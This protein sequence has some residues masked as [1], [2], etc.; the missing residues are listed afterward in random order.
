MHWLKPF[1]L[2]A[3]LF[4][5][6]GQVVWSA[7]EDMTACLAKG[8]E[9]FSKKQYEQA[10]KEFSRCVKKDRTNVDAHLSLAGVLLTLEDLQ[11]AEKSFH[12]ALKNM[13]RTSPYFS[14]TYSILGDIALKKQENEKAL[15]FY[16]RSL[17]FNAANVNSLVGKGVIIEYQGD[18]QG[19]S[20]YYR[21]ALAV[22]PLNLIARKRLI[23]LEPDYMTDAEILLSLK[24]RYAIAPETKELT[25]ED[26]NLF[27][28]IHRAEQRRGVDYLKNKKP[29]NL[30]SYYVTINKDSEFEREMLTL[31]G[32]KKLSKD[33]GQDAVAVFQRV[34]VPIQSI[35]D[36]RSLRGEK[37]F[38][39]ESTL[40][41]RGFFVYM[42]ALAGRK[43]FLL[44]NEAPPPTHAALEKIKKRV[45]ELKEAGYIEITHSEL[46]A[47]E[48]Q[49]LCSEETLRK[50][51]GLFIL[52]P[53]GFARR[54][55]IIARKVTDPL[56][57]VPFYYLMAAHAKRNPKIKVPSNSLVES[58][59]YY[60]YTICLK[61][62]SLLE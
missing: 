60:G 4:L 56:K 9:A 1:S 22:E 15:A 44:P 61:D 47:I 16:G 18:K 20:E 25:E 54:Y 48:N 24:Q 45:E 52:K 32:Y 36:L 5:L 57:G 8:K 10:K 55:F 21:S 33:I 40:T 46:K 6:C 7:Q 62:G 50:R 31:E 2:S 26:R 14:Y 23:N 3:G 49:T 17:S 43:A 41:E 35:F 39:E 42:E 59:S 38:T 27:S 13:K 51:M 34:G 53:A 58:Y 30:S 12:A 11:G 37:I 28:D 19:A 29:K